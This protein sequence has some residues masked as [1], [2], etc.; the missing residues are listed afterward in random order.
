MELTKRNSRNN[1]LAFLWHAVFLALTVSLVEV[2]TVV[3]AM[4]LKLGASSFLLGLFT[5]IT[6]G[7]ASFAHVFFAGILLNRPR[8]KGA[9]LLGVNL[10]VGALFGLGLTFA[11]S[12][13]LGRSTT[14]VILFLLIAL[15]SLSG[16]FA[17]ISFIDLLG[18]LIKKE[19]RKAFFTAKQ[20][21]NSAGLLVSTLV[22]RAILKGVDFPG[23]SVVLFSLAGMLLLVASLGFWRLREVEGEGYR[24]SFFS[25]IR[26]IPEEIR[27]N[28]NLKRYL[29]IMNTL[30]VGMGVPPFLL[31]YA[32]EHFHLTAEVVGNILFF[33][34]SGLLV[35][36]LFLFKF[37]ARFTYRE[38]LFAALGLVLA[39]LLGAVLLQ[40]SATASLFVFTLAGMFLAP[41]RMAIGGLLLE[42]S[43]VENR[44]VYAGIAG[45]G[46]ILPLIAPLMAG[47]VLPLV[48]FFPLLLVTVLIVASSGFFIRGVVCKPL[49]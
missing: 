1:L 36:G 34:T 29:G 27:R 16:A 15:F 2:N 5:T 23:N 47:A 11:W 8:K 3:P 35:A 46:S 9:L 24:R 38:L 40:G 25:F 37:A 49:R 4:L 28:P 42:I 22:A 18:R 30:G 41:Y 13:R 45:A 6:L 17:N 20:I 14:L 31:L 19:R 44:T 39:T 43:T 12:D 10:R 26:Q 32:R 33:I 21:I 48:S 7:G